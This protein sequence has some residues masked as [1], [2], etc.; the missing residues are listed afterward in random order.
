MLKMSQAFWS[1]AKRSDFEKLTL[2]EA[3]TQCGLI[4]QRGSGFWELDCFGSALAEK[5]NRRLSKT[6][7]GMGCHSV[8]FGLMQEQSLWDAT[9]RHLDYGQELFSLNDRR[10]KQFRLAATAEEAATC[11]AKMHSNHGARDMWCYQIGAKWRDETRARGALARAREFEMLD[12]YSFCHSID[13]AK[14]IHELSLDAFQKTLL[15]LG[16]ACRAEPA[17]CGEVGGLESVELVCKSKEL[18][19]GDGN[20]ELAHLFLLG[21]RYSKAFDLR[22]RTGEFLQMGCQGVGT[23]RLLMALL[24]S[25]RCATGF[26]GNEAAC[27]HLFWISALDYQRNQSTR[28]AAEELCSHAGYDGI[29]DDRDESAGRKLRDAEGCMAAYRIVVSARSLATGKVEVKSMDGSASFDAS[30]ED[31]KCFISER[32]ARAALAG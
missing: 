30:I 25:R 6:M 22:G 8:R 13:E 9:G 21:D 18:G 26:F 3:A 4:R 28:S 2:V 15:A 19:D 31:A 32:R 7:A 27:S 17:G 14:R 5:I 29:L 24:E 16:V 20:L 1:Q 11:A 12:A 10:G 23:T